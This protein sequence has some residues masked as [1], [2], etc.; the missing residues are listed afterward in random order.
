MSSHLEEQIKGVI[1][2]VRDFPKAGVVFRD[3]T[4]LFQSPRLLR[5]AMDD[6]VQRYIE[7]DFSH[8]G[9]M[10]ARGFLIG[11][12]IAYEL[13]RPLITFRKQG[14]LPAD[15]IGEAYQTEYGQA[16]LEVH[17]DSL[18]EGD[19]VL[20]VDD[21]I[22]TGGTLLAAARLVQRLGAEIFEV[23][24]II[25]L[26]ELGGTDRLQQAGISSYCLTRFRLAEN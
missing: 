21:L 9:V 1:R 24:A 17:R 18:C 15:V 16:I 4:P 23:A 12:I 3:I 25:D 11:S 10:D 6:L 14:K 5:M 13:N 22:A 8:V 2:P 20:L 19:R 26:P 7:T